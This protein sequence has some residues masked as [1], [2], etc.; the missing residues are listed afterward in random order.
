MA[1]K[2]SSSSKTRTK[3][4]LTVKPIA[5][6]VVE[7][8]RKTAWIVNGKAPRTVDELSF[9]SRDSRG[10]INWWDVQPPKTRYASAHEMLGRVYAF[11]I[12]DLLNNPSAME[13]ENDHILGYVMSAISKW[14]AT[15]AIPGA[16]A[17][18]YGF[19]SVIGEYVASG[20][21]EKSTTNWIPLAR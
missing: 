17:M 9:T 8:S 3:N 15:V 19:F 13:E 12:L 4:G 1:T 6:S 5:D 7:T 2:K 16:S 18:A 20:T 14:V 11:E 21:A 10:H